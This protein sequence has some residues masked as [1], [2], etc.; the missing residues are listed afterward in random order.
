MTIKTRALLRQDVITLHVEISIELQI[1]ILIYRLKSTN[2]AL[3]LSE[4]AQKRKE[5]MQLKSN[6]II[7]D[8][9]L[10]Q[11]KSLKKLETFELLCINDFEV[12]SMIYSEFILK[13][14]YARERLDLELQTS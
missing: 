8:S 14:Q 6:Y 2:L 7:I 11:S 9:F 13:T 4:I 1:V 10:Y 12:K 3:I 5:V